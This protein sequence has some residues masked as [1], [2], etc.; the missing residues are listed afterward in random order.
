MAS[1]QLSFLRLSGPPVAKRIS[2]ILSDI[3]FFSLLYLLACLTS[4]SVCGLLI[5]ASREIPRL[6]GRTDDLSAVQRAH[7]RLTPR[8]GGLGIIA[9][10]ILG[11]M[12][13]SLL[14]GRPALSDGG[15]LLAGPVLLVVVAL[16]EDLGFRIR[17]WTRLFATMLASLY[18]GLVTQIWLR[19]LDVGPLDP[20]FY[21]LWVAI[22]VT[23]LVTALL[24][25]GFNLIDGVN[26]L[27]SGVGLVGSLGCSFVCFQVGAEP[28]GIIALILS[29]GI[30]GFMIFNFPFGW[31]FLGDTGAYF[32]GFVLAWLGITLVETSG[33]AV[34][35]WALILL[36]FWPLAD[37][38]FAVF[39][40]LLSGRKMFEPDRLHMHSIVNRG[41]TVIARRY[42]ALESWRNPLTTLLLLPMFLVPPVLAISFYTQSVICFLLVCACTLSYAALYVG[43]LPAYRLA[44]RWVSEK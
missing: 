6:N 7:D 13:V 9:G 38:F 3:K 15:K 36:F 17:P 41:L 35:P 42:P 23:L 22:P 26:G 34:S 20:F 11:M 31:I 39:R 40:R 2:S 19:G 43:T 29:A 10:L 12:Y 1:R 30:I 28:I 37:V 5:A 4:A 8:I 18:V 21:P 14:L 33:G 44:R 24:S 32:I 16:A 27:S 25:H